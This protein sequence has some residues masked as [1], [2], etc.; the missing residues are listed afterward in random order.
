MNNQQ[1]N[2]QGQQPSNQSYHQYPNQQYPNQPGPGRGAYQNPNQPGQQYQG[3]NYAGRQPGYQGGPAGGASGGRKPPKK[4]GN[5]GLIIALIIIGILILLVGAGILITLIILGI[6]RNRSKEDSSVITTEEAVITTEAPKATTTEEP[7]TELTTEEIIQS[8][9][10]EYS[11]TIGNPDVDMTAPFAHYL[12]DENGNETTIP[13]LEA[14]QGTASYHIND[15][16]RTEADEDGNVTIT[17]PLTVSYRAE[18]AADAGTE[19]TSFYAKPVIFIYD[20]GDY[21]TGETL[22]PKRVDPEDD[23]PAA[24]PV[25]KA[26][27][28]PEWDGKTYTIKYERTAKVTESNDGKYEF[29]ETRDGRDIYY[30]DHSTIFIYK[31]TVPQDYDGLTFQFYKLGWNKNMS[32]AAPAEGQKSYFLQY[33]NDGSGNYVLDPADCIY[34]RFDPADLSI[35]EDVPDPALYS[36]YERPELSE[37][38]W[39][40]NDV[41]KNGMWQDADQISDPAGLTGSWK[42]LCYWDP[43][44]KSGYKGT[45][46]T[47]LDFYIA[48]TGVTAVMDYYWVEWAGSAR[49]DETS[50]DDTIYAGGLTESGLTAECPTATLDITGIYI[51]DGKEYAIGEINTNAG[52]NAKV[53]LVR[54]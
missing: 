11:F 28:T 49:E 21:Y 48:G 13:G 12:T 20:V 17:L 46:L 5:K 52:V 19:V 41:Y 40:I 50:M 4:G 45:E 14:L 24:T 30:I 35:S 34:Y 43:D 31:I 22:E 23:A 27:I 15:V 10:D 7:S 33:S 1:F 44:N 54:P 51:K 18:V 53:A 25:Y 8:Y 36:T 3:Q 37:F 38:D 47:N 29:L 9:G 42:C 26:E 2:N 39:Y 16:T 6:V 32:S